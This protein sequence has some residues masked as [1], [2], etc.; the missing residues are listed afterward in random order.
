MTLILNAPKDSNRSIRRNAICEKGA[1]HRRR[2]PVP[3]TQEDIGK[4]L[5]FS[6]VGLSGSHP[7]G[8]T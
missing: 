4:P 6:S 3:I 8:E 5:R 7:S 1:S 2:K